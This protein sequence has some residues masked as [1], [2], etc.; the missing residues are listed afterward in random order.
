[1]LIGLDSKTNGNEFVRLA[2]EQ[3]PQLDSVLRGHVG[4]PA[5][6][7]LNARCGYNE[8]IEIDN[9]GRVGISAAIRRVH[10]M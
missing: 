3:R 1:M 4:E 10:W 6:R 2:T 5:E 8:G 9:S 7:V